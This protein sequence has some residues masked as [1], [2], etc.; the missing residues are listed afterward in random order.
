ML[1]SSLKLGL[2]ER[3]AGVTLLALGN[4]APD[5]ASTVSAIITDKHRGYLMALGELTGAA[6]VS[7]TVIVG[8]VTYVAYTNTND[9]SGTNGVLCGG[10]L[11]RDVMVFIVTMIWVYL[12]FED[13]TISQEEIK[14]FV[15][16][17]V[18]YCA[19]VLA[20]DLYHK[21]IVVPRRR[22]A[23]QR[24]HMVGPS[25]AKPTLDACERDDVEQGG[26][27][28]EE[29][30][31]DEN[32]SLLSETK[33]KKPSSSSNL[34][35]RPPSSSQQIP[36]LLLSEQSQYKQGHQKQDQDLALKWSIS[37]IIMEAMSNYDAD[38]LDSEAGDE[39]PIIAHTAPAAFVEDPST[40]RESASENQLLDKNIGIDSSS[41][42]STRR[43]RVGAGSW[44]QKQEDGT[45]PLIVF[46][47][48]HGG[49]VNLKQHSVP[50]MLINGD[51]S[52]QSTTA[53]EPRRFTEAGGSSPEH[54]IVA[55]CSPENW[56]HAV[57][58]GWKELTQH[59]YKQLWVETIGNESYNVAEK[60]LMVCE[61]PFTVLRM[62]SSAS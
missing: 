42:H 56:Y 38:S 18:I 8:A 32:T 20:S 58:E 47:P 37:D 35:P 39:Y 10:S 29:F 19:I 13:G 22:R 27:E 1:L 24:L 12:S 36:Q 9:T 50:P 59:F 54:T 43:R 15:W 33:V 25:K 28:G 34:P 41:S 6:L 14:S 48:H 23:I 26:A 2:P 31:A 49:V 7:T 4:G 3:F 60:L 52:A 40:A 21:Y 5:V 44:G 45:E 55:C 51:P 46:H 11:V 53:V 16:L 61:L 62:V 30:V 57:V 17:Y